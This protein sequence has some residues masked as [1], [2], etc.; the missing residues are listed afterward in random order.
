MLT[1]S[2]LLDGLFNSSTPS[3]LLGGRMLKKNTVGS[4]RDKYIAESRC[5]VLVALLI[6]LPN[7]THAA[8]LDEI[9]AR[10]ELVVGVKSDYPSYGF[11]DGKDQFAAWSRIWRPTSPGG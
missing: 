4:R 7:K 9:R 5:L 1:L 6:P 3:R 11:K 10:G 2:E 8:L